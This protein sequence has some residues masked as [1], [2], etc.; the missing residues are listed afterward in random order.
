MK[1]IQS[2][3]VRLTSVLVF[4]VCFTQ[5]NDASFKRKDTD[6]PS[7]SPIMKNQTR[8]QNSYWCS[9]TVQKFLVKGQI[10][11]GYRSSIGQCL[12]NVVKNLSEFIIYLPPDLE[13]NGKV[14]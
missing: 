12:I 10:G 9:N 3:Y 11:L 2:S 7:S 5:R 13:G 1:K 4:Q 6:P 8:K 14:L